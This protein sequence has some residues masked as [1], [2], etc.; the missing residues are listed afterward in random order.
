MNEPQPL[1]LWFL[2]LF[3]VLF[4][5]MWM[6]VLGLLAELGGWR[7]LGQLYPAPRGMKPKAI[8]SF[9][10]TSADLRRGWFPLPVNYGNMIAVVVAAE[11]LHLRVWKIFAFRHP[12]LLIPW[13]QVERFESGRML[14]WRTLTLTPRG[15]NTRIRLYGAPAAA[16]ETLVTQ[17][18]GQTPGVV[19]A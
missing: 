10:M 11:G 6:L 13:T 15:T 12:P 16:I 19:G 9:G 3:P 7:E 4:L 18:A 1:P 8:R 14:F 5:G 17:L 2:P